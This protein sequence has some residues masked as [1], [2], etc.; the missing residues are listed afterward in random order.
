MTAMI[1]NVDVTIVTGCRNNALVGLGVGVGGLHHFEIYTVNLL[2]VFAG[3]MAQ[4]SKSTVCI[5]VVE[6]S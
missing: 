2:S 1:V 5:I 4:L 3:L 6:E